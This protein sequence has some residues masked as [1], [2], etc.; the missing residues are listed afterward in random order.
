[1][2]PSL[3]PKMSLSVN[4]TT[5]EFSITS[6]DGNILQRGKLG[7][8]MIDAMRGANPDGD[9]F[10]ID[11]TGGPDRL[12]KYDKIR[13]IILGQSVER[14]VFGDMLERPAIPMDGEPRH[15]DPAELL[16]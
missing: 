5:R 16:R 15:A 6:P 4:L 1:M 3:I 9:V 2:N 12:S 13:E 7:G 10:R 11:A 14:V 8:R